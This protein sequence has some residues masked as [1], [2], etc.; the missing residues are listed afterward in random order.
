M[1]LSLA[2]LLKA[3]QLKLLDETVAYYGTN[4]RASTESN[5]EYITQ[6]GFRCAVGRLLPKRVCIEI[7][8]KKVKSSSDVSVEFLLR[9]LE[10]SKL[11]KEKIG[12]LVDTYGLSFL[13]DLQYLHDD[14]GNW[15]K[16]P[17]D[18]KGVILSQYGVNYFNQLVKRINIGD[19]S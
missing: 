8:K 12:K 6:K 15:V 9:N 13:K 2:Q 14:K 5:C 4:S 16:N 3:N 19:Y 11:A 17:Q 18:G 10:L 1:S 7:E